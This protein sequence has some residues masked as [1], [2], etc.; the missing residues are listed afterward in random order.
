MPELPEVES[1]A[2]QLQKYLVGHRIEK[3]EVRNSKYAIHDQDVVGA[4]VKDI[5]RFAKVISIDLSNG[6]SILVHVKL[7]GQLIY[8]GPQLVL[9]A[10]QLSS[11]VIGGLGGKHTHL[12]FR[13][14]RGGVL[15][16][17]DFRRFGWVRVVLTNELENEDFIKHLGPELLKDMNLTKFKSILEKSSTAVK[18]LLMDQKKMSG[19][20]NIYANDALNVARI[21]PKIKANKLNNEQIKY[22]FK[23]VE[24]VLKEGIKRGGASELAFVNP[25]GSEGNYQKFTVVYGR[26]GEKCKNG[27]GGVI[28]KIKLGGRGTYFCPICQR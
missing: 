11:K 9:G 27:C 7:T 13:L 12:V 17:N 25:D 6:F 18:V 23:A 26:E 15:Y 22:L 1:I 24:K 14:D 2:N 20:G 16:Y 10:Y 19:V 8:R 3:V 28:K 21:N 4:K 5:R